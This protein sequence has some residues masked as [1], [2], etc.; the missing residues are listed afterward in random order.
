MRD[1][2]GESFFERAS[3]AT[4]T[5]PVSTDGDMPEPVPPPSQL[6]FQGRNAGIKAQEQD[7]SLEFPK[8]QSDFPVA[9]H[10]CGTFCEGQK[11]QV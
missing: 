7:S 9:E 1:L 11:C 2:P 8:V 5:C 3:G 6:A 10:H 4:R